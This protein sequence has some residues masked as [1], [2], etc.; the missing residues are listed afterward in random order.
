MSAVN[1]LENKIE[2]K[3]KF[4]VYQKPKLTENILLNYQLITFLSQDIVPTIE[5]LQENKV[6]PKNKFYTY[7]QKLS[8][9][10]SDHMFDIY[11][12][13]NRDAE[14]IKDYE[15]VTGYFRRLASQLLSDYQK[16]TDPLIIDTLY[17]IVVY[18]FIL[19]SSPF[20][21]IE[22]GN[23]P[24]G[25]LLSKI[26]KELDALK[27]VFDKRFEALSNAKFTHGIYSKLFYKIKYCSHKQFLALVD[28]NLK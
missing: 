1:F 28:G 21:V 17:A 18:E 7:L 16:S 4:P 5:Y 24:N 12:K 13:N 11:K 2:A 26:Q 19:S 9:D 22:Q 25:K 20:V 27:L 23:I 10:D 6:L 14:Y 3:V 8:D 15:V